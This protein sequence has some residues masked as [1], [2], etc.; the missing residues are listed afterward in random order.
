MPEDLRISG[1]HFQSPAFRST[2]RTLAEFLCHNFISSV[3][4]RRV[5]G[6]CAR[7]AGRQIGHRRNRFPARLRKQPDGGMLDKLVFGAGVGHEF[8][9]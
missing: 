4:L 9:S 8:N 6:F 2:R 1:K 3:C 7:R 5:L